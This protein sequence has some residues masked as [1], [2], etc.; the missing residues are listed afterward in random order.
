MGLSGFRKRIVMIIGCCLTGACVIFVSWG[1]ARTSRTNESIIQGSS[2]TQKEKS[3]P[4]RGA[5]TVK[6]YFF[7]GDKLVEVERRVESTDPLKA[8]ISNLLAG[9][10]SSE[11]SE[12]ISTAIPEGVRLISSSIESG[13]ARLDFSEE[14][15][16]Y[17]GGSTWVIAIENQIKKTVSAN[18][19]DVENI[20]IFIEGIPSEESLQP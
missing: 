10:T 16:K 1:C 12:G 20:E 14:M 18:C 6:V 17:G 7:K 4:P 15:K 2:K 8:A 19:R 3:Q 9:P 13:V 11:K 5:M